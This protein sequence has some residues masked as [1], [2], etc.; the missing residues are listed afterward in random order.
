MNIESEKHIQVT[1]PDNQVSY[2]EDD[3]TVQYN[4][5]LVLQ[6]IPC[7]PLS[8]EKGGGEVGRGAGSL[9]MSMLAGKRKV[10]TVSNV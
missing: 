3:N 7:T 8:R 1:L 4:C 5:T 6:I 9:L 2:K 10:G